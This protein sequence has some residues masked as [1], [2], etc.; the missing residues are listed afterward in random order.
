MWWHGSEVARQRGGTAVRWH[1]SEV[2]R[3]RGGRPARWHGSKV[4]G[5]QGG[6]AAR[7]H[8]SEVARQRG[9]T[10]ARWHASEVARQRGGTAARWHASEVARQRGDTAARWQ[11]SEVARQ[12][13]GRPARWQASKV[14][15]QQGGTAAAGKSGMSGSCRVRSV[16]PV[17]LLLVVLTCSLYRGNCELCSL[18]C[19]WR[20]QDESLNCTWTGDRNTQYTLYLQSLT[21]K[22]DSP[23]L[24][25]TSVIGLNWLVIPRALLTKYWK[26]KLRVEGEDGEQ[27]YTFSY[28]INDKNLMIPPPALLSSILSEDPWTVEV[29]W[30]HPRGLAFQDDQAVELRYRI[31]GSKDW[32][33]VDKGELE[34]NAYEMV[35]LEPFSEYEV[36]VRYPPDELEKRRGSPWS[37]SITFG[38]PEEIPI[39]SLDVWR[40]YQM[41]P[42]VSLV[43]KPLDYRQARGRVSRY[44][45]TYI[46]SGQSYDQEA[47]C[48]EVRLPANSTHMCVSALNGKGSGPDTC[49]ASQ[50]PDLNPPLDFRIWCNL[51]ESVTVWWDEP[52]NPRCDDFTYLVEWTKLTRAQNSTVHWARSQVANQNLTLPGEFAAHVPYRVSAY[53]L[54]QNGCEKAFSTIIYSQEGAPAAAPDVSILDVS[55]TEA[56]ISWSEIPIWLQSGFLTHYTVYLN[57]PADSKQHKVSGRNLSLSGLKPM[58]E[59]S[60]WVT[61]STAAGEGPPGKIQGFNTTGF[62]FLPVILV[63][64][65]ITLA[66]FMLLI[67]LYGQRLICWPEIPKPENSRLVGALYS[68]KYI[69][70]PKQVSPNLPITLIEEVEVLSTILPPP[71]TSCQPSI[72]V[73]KDVELP[74]SILSPLMDSCYPPITLTGDVDLPPPS[75]PTPKPSSHPP[76]VVAGE[77][78]LPPPILPPPMHSCHSPIPVLDMELPKPSL[79]SSLGQRS[80]PITVVEEEALTL[81]SMPTLLKCPNKFGY[82]K[83]F[84]PSP[85]EVLGLC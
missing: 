82:E 41:G 24:N 16:V 4:A 39:G 19:I 61:A 9:G 67:L 58:T 48:C 51:T 36:Q 75:R 50:C 35:D 33:E 20:V 79:Y 73:I 40:N 28:N 25:F 32:Q 21:L 83:H 37:D 38:T 70:G 76:I 8:G 7:W 49:A 74:P 80:S 15:R 2:A 5:Q 53:L 11:A 22:S 81:P 59:Y 12:Q 44:N 18:C 84:M 29:T 13:G 1:G 6:T 68:S 72:N 47:A 64:A 77:E 52:L 43:W 30:T 69:W 3:Q 56:V 23:V 14:A 31:V 10:A 57:S 42:F 71:M 17:F 60:V 27:I 78:E 26:Y 54:Y 66:V 55:S 45:V 46:H 65:G 63:S 34:P 62:S 85:E